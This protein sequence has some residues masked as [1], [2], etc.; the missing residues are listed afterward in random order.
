MVGG[1]TPP[2][3]TSASAA[4]SWQAPT[5]RRTAVAMMLP[6]E[7]RSVDTVTLCA[8]AGG[9]SRRAAAV[10]SWPYVHN[11]GGHR[12]PEAGGRGLDDGRVI[13]HAYV[14][15]QFCQRVTTLRW[16][17]LKAA[18]SETPSAMD[19]RTTRGGIRALGVDVTAAT[20]GA[21]FFTHMPNVGRF[22][23]DGAVVGRRVSDEP[24]AILGEAG[25]PSPTDFCETQEVVGI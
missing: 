11:R 17:W 14:S 13:A 24:P 23:R 20:A 12:S 3:A 6:P 4:Q 2:L 8:C 1:S 9:A 25:S 18:D 16:C 22:G 19:F 10:D 21:P 7:S 5:S 15:R